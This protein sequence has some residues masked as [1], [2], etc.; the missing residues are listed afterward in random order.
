MYPKKNPPCNCG[1]GHHSRWEYDAQGIPLCKVC[2]LC[3]AEKLAQYRP[4]ILEGYTQLDV[5]EPIEPDDPY[6]NPCGCA[7]TNPCGC[8][9]TY[10]NPRAKKLSKRARTH[11]P[12]R[13][14]IFPRERKW[15]IPDPAHA[16]TALSW[17]DWPQ[18]K[19]VQRTVKSRYPQVWR[20]FKGHK[21]IHNPTLPGYSRR[22]EYWNEHDDVIRSPAVEVKGNPPPKLTKLGGWTA[23]VAGPRES[24][25]K[26]V[27]GHTATKTLKA[28]RKAIEDTVEKKLRV[29]KP[30]RWR[31]AV[32]VGLVPAIGR[33]AYVEEQPRLILIMAKGDWSGYLG[34]LASDTSMTRTRATGPTTVLPPPAVPTLPPPVS[35]ALPNPSDL[36]EVIAQVREELLQ[37]MRSRQIVPRSRKGWTVF[38]AGYQRNARDRYV[39][40][41]GHYNYIKDARKA[42][43]EAARD[44]SLISPKEKFRL[45]RVRGLPSTGYAADHPNVVAMIFKGDWTNYLN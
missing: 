14:F 27:F 10:R 20:D 21:A 25:G 2:P 28:A 4:E 26:Y 38:I 40:A 34:A 9:E 37:T 16:M 15:P 44:N 31:K 30:I 19:S 33:V 23:I 7:H 24:D 39:S 36:P 1:S 13:D 12:S 8:C 17:S 6:E 42:L 11:L 35:A 3:R 29:C 5:D 18:H 32:D 22:H 43:Y 45:K 41:S